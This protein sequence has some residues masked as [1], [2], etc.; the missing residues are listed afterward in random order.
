MKTIFILW[1]ALAIFC[2]GCAFVQQ[3]AIDQAQKGIEKHKYDAALEHLQE[4]A[5]YTTPTPAV[6][7]QIAYMEAICYE[8]L[9]SPDQ[10]TALFKYAVDHYPDTEYAYMAREKL[11][12]TDGFI[13]ITGPAITRLYDEQFQKQVA[14]RWKNLLKASNEN[15]V[16]TGMVF[17]TF[18]LHQDGEIT[19]LTVVKNTTTAALASICKKALLNSGAY[20]G[21]TPEMIKAIDK[22]FRTMRFTFNYWPCHKTVPSKPQNSARIA[23]CF[24]LPGSGVATAEKNWFIHG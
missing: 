14:E 16:H 22:P 12:N 17:V 13:S 23:K 3:G 10:A 21:G 4:A 9:N 11:T 19:D 15:P 24:R 1:L 7:A 18:K 6:G 8:E 20:E 2:S 5:S